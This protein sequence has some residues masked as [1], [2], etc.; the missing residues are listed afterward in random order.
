MEWLLGL[1]AKGL[2]SVALLS[3]NLYCLFIVYEPKI[4]A[5]LLNKED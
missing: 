1:A 4:P 5:A 2:Y 3:S